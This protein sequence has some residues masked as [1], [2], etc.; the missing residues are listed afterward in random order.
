M[1]WYFIFLAIVLMSMRGTSRRQL[2]RLERKIELLLDRL[3][4]DGEEIDAEIQRLELKST[5]RLQTL[6]QER[7]Q[8]LIGPTFIGGALGYPLG[9]L[10]SPVVG[11]YSEGLVG[12]ILWV[13]IG[14]ALGLIVGL[15]R[16]RNVRSRPVQRDE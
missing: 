16:C 2:D 4:V 9:M 3:A 14:M 7:I 11:L 10:L 15:L 12:V 6:R 13:P 5:A 8:A 1:E